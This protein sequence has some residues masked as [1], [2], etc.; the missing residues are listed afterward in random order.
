M[1]AIPTTDTLLHRYQHLMEISRDLVSTFDLDT[2]LAHIVA[3]AV[4][5]SGSEAA[6]I[7]LVDEANQQLYF[8]A[9]SNMA[10]LPMI[11]GMVV[12]SEG[13]LAGWVVQNRQPVIVND[14]QKDRRHDESVDEK[15]RFSTSSLMGI[16]LV[17]KDKTIGV[18]EVLN[19]IDGPFTSED[20]EVMTILGAL[21]AI[22]IQNTRLFQ[23]SDLIAELVH[24]LRTPLSSLSAVAHLLMKREIEEA[25]RDRL[26]VIMNGEVQRLNNMATSF[27]DLA[28]LESGRAVFHP[29]SFD[30]KPLL[31]ECVFVCQSKAAENQLTIGI[32]VMPGLPSL[33]ADRDKIKQVLLNLISNAIKYNRTGGSIKL[34]VVSRLREMRIS[35][36][37]TGPGILPDE[38][39][40]LFEK[41]FRASRTERG[42][43]GTGLGLS[44]CRRII[45][46]HRG[47]IEVESTVGKGTRFTLIL[48]LRQNPSSKPN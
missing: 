9:A 42:T 31:E 16:P 39:P 48:P 17:T 47:Q 20:Q 3:V 34:Q 46:A 12:P 36:E 27:L 37:D 44:I 5:L 7:L 28:R 26:V 1:T 38:L 41:F 32:E 11:R 2:L 29:T 40:H 18:L 13:S 21:A 23:Q 45:D 24:E 14:V 4:D 8:Q 33:E 6:S 22:A 19:K 25:Q 10:D 43:P 30:L 35:V 15:T